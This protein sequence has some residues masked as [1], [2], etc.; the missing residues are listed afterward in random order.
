MTAGGDRPDQ[1]RQPGDG[2]PEHECPLATFRRTSDSGADPCRAEEDRNADHGDG[3]NDQRN[4][5]VGRQDERSDGDLPVEGR[6]NALGSCALV[7]PHP[8]HQQGQCG[9]QLGDADRGDGQDETRRLGEPSD[10]GQFDD[11]AERDR[12]GKTDTETE[13]IRQT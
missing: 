5:V 12:G 8:W 11:R 6:G 2:D 4:E 7:A 3:G 10:E 13:Q 9:E 1:R